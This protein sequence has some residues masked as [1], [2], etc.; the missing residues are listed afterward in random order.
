MELLYVLF[1]LGISMIC[2]VFIFCSVSYVKK[3]QLITKFINKIKT[4]WYRNK[5]YR[6]IKQVYY[7]GRIVY[8]LQ[9]YIGNY[10]IDMDYSSNY[11][12]IVERYEELLAI[13]LD[14]TVKSTRTV[15]VK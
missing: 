8:K 9:K 10:F 2:S 1:M 15:K 3:N 5:P 12:K 4:I 6:I 11:E 13:Y 7:N 14:S